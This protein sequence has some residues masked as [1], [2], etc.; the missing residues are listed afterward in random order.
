MNYLA[1]A[2]LSFDVPGILVG[3]MISDF[4]KGKKKFEYKG[5]I[6]FGIDLH[7]AIDDYTDSHPET[8]KA[9]TVYQEVYGL[10]SGAFMDVTYD[11]FIANDT[12]LFKTSLETFSNNVYSTLEA[13]NE[14]FP[15]RFASMFPYMKKHNWLLNYR[16]KSGIE[17]SFEGLVHRAEYMDDSSSAYQTFLKNIGVFEEAYHKFFPGL[18][19][20]AREAIATRKL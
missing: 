6:R 7:R 8:K 13:Y 20:F 1:H 14:H 17:R 2:Y 5:D 10:Y 16:N 3:N 12:N 4:V 18:A 15:Q 11:Y 9:K 19:D